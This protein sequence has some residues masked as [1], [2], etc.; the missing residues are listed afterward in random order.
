MGPNNI[1]NRTCHQNT[2]DYCVSPDH[3]TRCPTAAHAHFA[4][5][6]ELNV[7]DSG[8]KYAKPPGEIVSAGLQ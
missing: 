3:G 7:V 6:F 1:I 5:H 2:T 4:S 8:P